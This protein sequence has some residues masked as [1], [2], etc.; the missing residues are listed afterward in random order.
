MKIG[1]I[2]ILSQ[3]EGILFT[4][5]DDRHD[6]EYMRIGREAYREL[7]GDSW[8]LV[9]DDVLIAYLD[10]FFEEFIRLQSAKEEAGMYR[11]DDPTCPKI[12]ID[13]FTILRQDEDSTWIQDNTTGEGAAF[14]NELCAAKL[15]SFFNKHF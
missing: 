1:G 4:V 13:R 7:I 8:E 14:S 2:R 3:F 12:V 6:R 11:V 15:I 9:T 5:T 10:E